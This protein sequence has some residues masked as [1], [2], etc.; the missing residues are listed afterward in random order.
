[1]GENS[2]EKQNLDIVDICPEFPGAPLPIKHKTTDTTAFLYSQNNKLIIFL[3]CEFVPFGEAVKKITGK[4]EKRN[5][6]DCWYFYYRSR[7]MY[8]PLRVLRRSIQKIGLYVEN[9]YCELDPEQ[10]TDEIIFEI[11]PTS[12]EPLPYE[13]I[14][15]LPK[16]KWTSK[17]LSAFF[18]RPGR[19]DPDSNIKDPV[20]KRITHFKR[21][22]KNKQFMF[23]CYWRH[24]KSKL[25]AIT[26]QK[27][28][29]LFP[30]PEYFNYIV[31]RCQWDINIE[32]RKHIIFDDDG[33]DI[34]EGPW[35]P[36]LEDVPMNKIDKNQI[37][38]PK[39]TQS[40]KYPIMKMRP[41]KNE[42]PN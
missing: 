11:D 31:H 23:K 28:V 39:K 34:E 24:P 35:H 19:F 5:A 42:K 12:E 3:N 21:Y 14:Y 37:V 10:S 41:S 9:T 18:Q 40:E 33:S 38:Q 22:G 6:W 8:F 30:N 25:P 7:N 27:W 32:K 20:L 13:N 1:M 17:T 15:N 26:W 2:F 29:E 36:D 16:K 4:N